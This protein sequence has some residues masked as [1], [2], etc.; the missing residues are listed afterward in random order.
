MT[1]YSA[2]LDA[3]AIIYRV[4]FGDHILCVDSFTLEEERPHLLTKMWNGQWTS[5]PLGRK[6]CVLSMGCRV[7]A[8]DQAVLLPA[9]RAALSGNTAFS[10]E[11]AD[12]AFS[13]MRLTAFSV[14]AEE[15][16]RCRRISLTFIGSADDIAP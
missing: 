2:A 16:A 5:S 13:D 7:L 14:K 8:A 4:P 11:L 10:F 3:A 1:D 9:L 12:T 15:G 6:P